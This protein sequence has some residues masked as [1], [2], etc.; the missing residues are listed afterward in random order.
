MKSVIDHY[1]SICVEL[2]N[3]KGKAN[4]ASDVFAKVPAN[5]I[6]PLMPR[7]HFEFGP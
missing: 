6:L 4:H 2:F 3:H 1:K 5:T 7:P